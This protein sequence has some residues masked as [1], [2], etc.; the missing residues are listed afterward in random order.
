MAIFKNYK[1]PN[2][3]PPDECRHIPQIVN[4]IA[5]YFLK[6]SEA[7]ANLAKT[8]V[9]EEFKSNEVI[10]NRTRSRTR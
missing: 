10:S 6:K 8:R 1:C 2:G 9:H 5:S 7:K 3:L 4:N